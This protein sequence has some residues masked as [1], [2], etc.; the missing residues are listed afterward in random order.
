MERNGTVW[1]AP[2]GFRFHYDTSAAGKGVRANK[3]LWWRLQPDPDCSSIKVLNLD[4]ESKKLPDYVWMNFTDNYSISQLDQ[5][6]NNPRTGE[7]ATSESLAKSWQKWQVEDPEIPALQ[8]FLHLF[9]PLYGSVPDN[10]KMSF[11]LQNLHSIGNDETLQKEFEKIFGWKSSLPT[12]LDLAVKFASAPKMVSYKKKL[13]GT[14]PAMKKGYYFN[15]YLAIFNLDPTVTTKSAPTTR[16]RGYLSTVFKDFLKEKNASIN[17]NAENLQPEG[18]SIVLKMDFQSQEMAEKARSEF[19][20]LNEEMENLLNE[21]SNHKYSKKSLRKLLSSS[22]DLV[23]FFKGWEASR[24]T[25][26]WR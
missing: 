11:H 19:R 10:E 13:F 6:V 16:Y 26:P 1:T 4:E 9:R 8:N 2:K 20:K 7:K 21:M 17:L 5:A 24:T 15:T 22:R 14:L 23:S 25:L 3:K 12:S 18:A